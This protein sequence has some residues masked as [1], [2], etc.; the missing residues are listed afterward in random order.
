[1]GNTMQLPFITSVT[2]TGLGG[3]TVSLGSVSGSGEVS[4]SS[5]P[6]VYGTPFVLKVGLL[7]YTLPVLTSANECDFAALLTG[8]QVRGP[9]SET[10]TDY[11]ISSA[12]G[13]AYGSAGATAVAARTPRAPLTLTAFPNPSSAGVEL[14]VEGVIPADAHVEIFDVA[15]RRVRE[16][17][18]TNSNTTMLWDGRGER[19]SALPSGTYFVRLTSHAGVASSRVT[20]LR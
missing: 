15:G 6:F 7:S 14:R 17:S 16:L 5:I 13:T 2:N 20:L 10:V 3:F 4:S 11:A 8:I 1:M 19:G 9:A 12:S 18:A